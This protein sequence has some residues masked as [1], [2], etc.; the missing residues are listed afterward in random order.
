MAPDQFALLQDKVSVWRNSSSTGPVDLR[1]Y[2]R[3]AAEALT[4]AL[5]ERAVLLAAARLLADVRPGNWDDDDDHDQVA[6]WNAL[7]AAIARATGAAS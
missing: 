1:D 5:V 3:R 6:A 7:D 2:N 4:A